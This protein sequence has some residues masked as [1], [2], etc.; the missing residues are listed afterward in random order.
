MKVTRLTGRR[1]EMSVVNDTQ[2]VFMYECVCKGEQRRSLAVAVSRL[3][4]T[5]YKRFVPIDGFSAAVLVTDTS[6]CLSV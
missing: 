1:C 5:D 6:K 4:E 3:H 2:Y